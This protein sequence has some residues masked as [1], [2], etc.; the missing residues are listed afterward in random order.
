MAG[1]NEV[2]TA[3]NAVVLYYSSVDTRLFVQVLL[4]LAVD[5]ADNRL[6][7]VWSCTA[8]EGDKE[9]MSRSFVQSIQCIW[10]MRGRGRIGLNQQYVHC[11]YCAISIV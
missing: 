1:G 2:E 9:R 3:V 11:T 4:V 6:P 10:N 7:A 8:M 5:I